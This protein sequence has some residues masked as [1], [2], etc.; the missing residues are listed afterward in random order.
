M[1]NRK[2]TV[3]E[4][5]EQL[6]PTLARLK[7]QQRQRAGQVPPNYFEELPERVLARIRAE[8]PAAAPAGRPS[9][10]GWRSHWRYA[11][12]LAA[13]IALLLLGGYWFWPG[14]TVPAEPLAALDDLSQEG[15]ALYIHEH[16]E[17]F[18][19]ELILEAVAMQADD[20][21]RLELLPDL[22]PDQLAPYLDEAIE[23]L[24]QGELEELL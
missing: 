19:W 4:E 18:D 15:L 2:T 3:Q 8:A 14:R 21:P 12:S 7:E 9:R 11:A 1:N 5:L 6:S 20:L 13:A 16:I 17:A 22:P 24:S 23:G 10:L